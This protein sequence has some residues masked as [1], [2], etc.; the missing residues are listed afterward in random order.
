MD[1]LLRP[2]LVNGKEIT[3]IRPQW[4]GTMTERERFKRQMHFQSFDRCYNMEFGYWRENYQVWEPFKQ[5]GITCEQEAN[6]F[7]GFDSSCVSGTWSEKMSLIPA[8][9]RKEIS[10]TATSRIIQDDEG[11]LVEELLDHPERMPRF[12][13]PAVSNPDDW[14]RLKEERLRRDDPARLRDI[15]EMKKWLSDDRTFPAGIYCGSMIGIVRDLLSFEGLCYAVYDYPEMVEDMVET[16]CQLAEDDLDRLLPHIQFDF[17]SGWEDICY[18]NGPIVSVP[19]FRDVVVP[20]YKRLHKK[21]ASY[22]I[23]LWWVDCDGDV[24]PLLP[25]FLDSGV[26]CL[27][28]YEV[29]SCMHPG[30]LMDQCDGRL[31]IMGG[32]DKM[33]LTQSKDDIYA[34][35]KSLVKY[36]ER[37]GFIPFCDHRCPPNVPWENYIYYLDIK[38]QMFGM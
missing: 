32:V 25:Y 31:R 8:F 1:H 5:N 30:E 13:K 37:G 17:A 35:M 27:L 10:R 6:V 9:E 14:K 22:G 33:I 26:N 38:E 19:F 7:F 28:P 11:A 21:I 24:R 15:G 18:K 12:I 16:F 29:N 20:R 36:V 23:D 3:P 34:Y 4:K 2:V